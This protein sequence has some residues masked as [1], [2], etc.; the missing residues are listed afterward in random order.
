M[1]LFPFL[2]QAKALS[3]FNGQQQPL[4][5]LLLAGVLWQQQVVEAG[6]RGG[7][8]VCVPSCPL[9]HQAQLPQPAHRRPASMPNKVIKAAVISA[10]RYLPIYLC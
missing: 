9:Y 6:V 2:L 3:I 7:Q 10:K 4:L 8:A 1:F 5:E